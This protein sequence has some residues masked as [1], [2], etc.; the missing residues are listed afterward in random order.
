MMKHF[1]S[2]DWIDYVRDLQTPA[3]AAQMKAHLSQC[4]ECQKSFR[5]WTAV[6]QAVAKDL[7]FAP[8][9]DAVRIARAQFVPAK[10]QSF[11]GLMAKLIFDSAQQPLTVG[12]RGSVSICRQ[13]L[14][15]HGQRFIDLRVETHPTTREV[16]LT[17]QIQ[18]STGQPEIIPVALCNGEEAIQHT[19][20]NPRGEFHMMFV[21]AEGLHLEIDMNEKKI[22]V[23]VP[24]VTESGH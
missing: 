3:L 19:E 18:Q 7:H 12:V 17:G 9:S 8:P 2:E 1:T 20:T 24:E 4:D 10:P 23:R 5:L 11:G 6:N 16:S 15:Q 22:R 13:L 21:P 14:Y